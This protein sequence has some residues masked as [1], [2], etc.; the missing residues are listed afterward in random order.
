MVPDDVQEADGQLR[1]RYRV[2]VEGMPYD[3]DSGG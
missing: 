2:L 1:E 3:M